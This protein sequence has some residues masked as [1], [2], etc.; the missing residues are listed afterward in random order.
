M[1]LG[2]AARARVRLIVW[3]VEGHIAGRLFAPEKINEDRAAG[4]VDHDHLAVDYRLVDIE[5]PAN[6][7]GERLEPAQDVAVARNE[8]ATAS[9]DIAEAP[10]AIVFELKEPFGSSNGSFR[11]VGMIGWTRGS[12]TPADMARPADL[13]NVHRLRV[14]HRTLP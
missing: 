7:V 13:S 8:A 3:C 5:Q 1:T 11:Q 4:L 2:N 14:S 6:L 10:E 12:V 9:L